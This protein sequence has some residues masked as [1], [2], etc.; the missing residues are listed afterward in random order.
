M[1][2]DD[3][4]GSLRAGQVR[5]VEGVVGHMAHDVLVQ[6]PFPGGVAVVGRDRGGR[7]WLG[8]AER[9]GGALLQGTRASC[10]RIS[11]GRYVHGGR[12]PAGALHCRV[13]FPSEREP[14]TV[15]RGAW[16]AVG[17]SRDAPTCFFDAAGRLVKPSLPASWLQGH[18]DDAVTACP[19]CDT[20]D[21]RLARADDPS[22]GS[23]GPEES[24]SPSPFAVCDACGHEESVGG[25]LRF[26]VPVGADPQLSAAQLR[27]VGRQRERHAR[28]ARRALK[29]V[30]CP[31]YAD[32][33]SRPR[34]DGWGCSGRATDSISLSHEPAGRSWIRVESEAVEHAW[35]PPVVAARAALAQ[36]FSEDEPSGSPDVSDAAVILWAHEFTRRQER[37]AAQATTGRATLLVD[38][39]PHE[40]VTVEEGDLRA[41]ALRTDRTAL[42]L[43]T[44]GVRLTDVRLVRLTSPDGQVDLPS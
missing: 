43:V 22:R 42:T 17:P 7:L 40:V 8:T 16:L 28:E 20:T 4:A 29:S 5:T 21:W 26:E 12:L 10:F 1:G 19:A 41:T 34:L 44:R 37:R 33:G 18:V 31:V 11:D 14:A 6:L 15:G 36:A 39:T 3:H 23:E 9:S 38:G 25:L 27:D 2:G 32:A 24:P 30:V 35:N 13:S